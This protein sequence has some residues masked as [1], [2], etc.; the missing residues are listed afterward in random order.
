MDPRELLN[1]LKGL[2][3]WTPPGSMARERIQQLINQLKQHLGN[4]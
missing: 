4:G 2:M 3:V 1:W